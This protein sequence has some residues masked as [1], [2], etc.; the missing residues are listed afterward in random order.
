MTV[1]AAILLPVFLFFFL[2]LLSFLE[3]LRLH[4]KIEMGL[5]DV[6]SDLCLYS[7]AFTGEETIAH[8]EEKKQDW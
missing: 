4:G 3:I 1:E 2:N 6:G 7:Y 5:W 8:S